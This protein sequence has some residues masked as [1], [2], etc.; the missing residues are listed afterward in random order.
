MMRTIEN[1][2]IELS[3]AGKDVTIIVSGFY[4]EAEKAT[5]ISPPT[6][7]QYE[8]DLELESGEDVS[9]LLCIEHVFNVV[10]EKLKE[11]NE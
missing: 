1:T 4:F 7:E 2:E 9:E 8:L 3:I 5:S 11:A 6:Q 10:V